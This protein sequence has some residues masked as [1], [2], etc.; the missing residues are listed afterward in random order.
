MF[1]CERKAGFPIF[2]ETVVHTAHMEI[3]C[4]KHCMVGSEL[5]SVQSAGKSCAMGNEIL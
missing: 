1:L 4:S 5:F 2:S 3:T